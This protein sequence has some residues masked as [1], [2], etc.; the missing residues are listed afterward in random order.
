MEITP[1]VANALGYYVYA[2]VDPR[3]SQ[4]FYIGKGTG[5]RATSHLN[6]REETKKVARIADIKACGMEPRID[7]IAY[8]LRDDME[9]KR[10]ETALIEL[11]GIKNLTNQIRGQDAVEYFR[12]PLDDFLMEFA[13]TQ[14][15]IQEP[16]LLIRINKRYWYGISEL[17]LYES[18]RGIWVIGSRRKNARYAMAVYAGIIREVYEIESWHQAGSTFYQTRDRQELKQHSAKRWEFIGNLARDA[19]RQKYRGHSVQHLFKKGQ[20]SPIVGV[21]LDS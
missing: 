7:M 17:E 8:N 15:E 11:I 6:D 4:I 3:N 5:S 18:T 2:Y 21:G 14:A 12:K 16:C 1:D 10:V 9:A 20:Q 13:P 19:I